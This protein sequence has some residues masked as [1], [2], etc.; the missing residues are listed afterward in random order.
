MN[1]NVSLYKK[2]HYDAFFTLPPARIGLSPRLLHI[3]VSRS[4]DFLPPVVKLQAL[5]NGKSGSS[6]LEVNLFDL[7]AQLHV[8]LLM[9][10]TALVFT[11][12][13]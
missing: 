5:T 4:I 2:Y 8:S 3:C 12:E 1:F 6:A 9:L 10:V 13:M 11:L 7:S